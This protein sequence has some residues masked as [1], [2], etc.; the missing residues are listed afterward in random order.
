MTSRNEEGGRFDDKDQLRR[1]VDAAKSRYG[2][3][4]FEKVLKILPSP[5]ERAED[6]ND[7]QELTKIL[8]AYAEAFGVDLLWKTLKAVGFE[9]PEEEKRIEIFEGGG[10]F[11]SLDHVAALQIEGKYE[12]TMKM[13]M[14]GKSKG[15]GDGFSGLDL[16]FIIRGRA[17]VK[18]FF[19]GNQGTSGDF[20][21]LNA[22][23]GDMGYISNSLFIVK[24]VSERTDMQIPKY[25][26][27]K[28]AAQ[29]VSQL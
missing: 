1:M 11:V 6:L 21:A 5:P 7:E 4:I 12:S 27:T 8:K 26:P 24:Q 29:S 9:R 28:A 3:K 22:G 25:T 16:Q 15:E 23:E 10:F 2:K 14:D 18:I 13:P 19:K 20:F 17:S